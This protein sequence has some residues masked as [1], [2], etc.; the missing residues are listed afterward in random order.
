MDLYLTLNNILCPSYSSIVKGPEYTWYRKFCL[1][2]IPP[3]KEA[4]V[5]E[6]NYQ[7][8]LEKCRPTIDYIVLPTNQLLVGF[9]KDYNELTSAAVELA[10]INLLET[11]KAV[12]QAQHSLLNIL[13]LHK[14]QQPYVAKYPEFFI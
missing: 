9:T 12:L 1:I 7:R 5:Y 14:E 4:N 13:E 3:K 11:N 10:T 8:E 2:T 6:I